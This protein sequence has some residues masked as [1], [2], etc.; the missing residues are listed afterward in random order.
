MRHLMAVL[1]AT[2]FLLAAS[3]AMSSGVAVAAPAHRIDDAR[4]IVDRTQSDLRRA[5]DF[6]RRKGKEISRYEN[7]EKHLSDF[8]KEITKG[9]FDKG[10]LDEA[11]DDVKNV[12]EHNTLDPDAR[13]ALNADL[14]DLRAVRVEHDK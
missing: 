11:I 5:A 13:D 3:Y 6:E 4:D 7:A 2:A 1:P 10:K 14:R 9:H 8:D 12:V